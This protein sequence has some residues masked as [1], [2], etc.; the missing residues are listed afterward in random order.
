MIDEKSLQEI[1]RL[2]NEIQEKEG[3]V[4]DEEY[5]KELDSFLD[6]TFGQEFE[7]ELNMMTRTKTIKIKKL[8]PDAIIPKYNYPSD[9]GFDLHSV[10]DVIIPA[11]GRAL[12][13]TGLS[14]QFDEGLEIQ[15]RPKS[16]L[17]INQGL[18]ILNT[19]GTI[20]QGYSG[21]VKAIVFNTN[22]VPYTITKGMK[23][24]QAVLCPVFNGKYVS[25]EEV[26]TFE[27]TDRQDNGFGSTGII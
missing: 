22:S 5:Q 4:P 15:M 3:F 27:E 9:S 20:D 14:F 10:E 6:M 7:N 8:H 25:L 19:P 13:P 12:V 17:A 26:D 1:Q 11:L 23:V 2:M 21:E 18:T 16:G 24:G